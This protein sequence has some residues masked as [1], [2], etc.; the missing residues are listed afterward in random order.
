MKKAVVFLANGFEEIEALTT[1]DVLRR[2][3]ALVDT[4]SV[5]ERQVTGAHGI[6]VIADKTEENFNQDDYDA[7]ILPGGMP[8]AK[9][10]GECKTVVGCAATFDARHKVVAA[11]CAAPATVLGMNGL[12]ENRKVTCYPADQFVRVLEGATYTGEELTVDGNLITANGPKAAM[13]FALAI[14]EKLGLEPTF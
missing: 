6:K 10:L 5:C 7:V 11:I 2:A 9:I 1:V 3:G 8:G 14:C 13:R 4:V 12:T